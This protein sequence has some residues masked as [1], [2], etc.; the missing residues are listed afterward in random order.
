MTTTR[1]PVVRDA[2]DRTQSARGRRS[3]AA[4]VG[5]LDSRGR[6]SRAMAS[7]AAVGG[8]RRAGPSVEPKVDGAQAIASSDEARPRT[9][10][11][12]S[13]TSALRWRAVPKR[14]DADVSSRI[15]AVSWRSGTSSR[16]CGTRLR[17]VAFQSMRRTSSPGSYGRMRSRSEP[18]PRT[19]APA[20]TAQATTDPTRETELEMPG[21]S[22]AIGPGPGRAGVRRRPAAR[23][24][25]GGRLP[26]S[27]HALA[28]PAA[29]MAG[30]L[31][32]LEDAL[33]D[34]VGGDAIG[35]RR[36]AHDQSMAQDVR[37]KG[38]HVG[39]QHVA[40][41]MEQ[42]QGAGAVDEVDRAT[43]AGTVGHIRL[44]IGRAP[45]AQATGGLDDAHGV[46]R[47]ARST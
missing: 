22:S 9:M 11:A 28:S 41:A 2:A 34:R 46:T 5:G 13:A 20:I 15:Q 12:P 24:R 44:E 4:L 47:D 33:D 10:A 35:Q 26:D 8:V 6:T 14:I 29:S 30:A 36:V 16:T 45:V 7:P 19:E 18:L 42:R 23:R 1:P 38:R 40:A 25:S 43:R 21:D 3:P 39:R 17:A 32:R 27:R 37:G 31:T